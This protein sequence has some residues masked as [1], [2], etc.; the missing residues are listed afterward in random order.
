[1]NRNEFKLYK[2]SIVFPHDIWFVGI[3]NSMRMLGTVQHVD[4]ADLIRAQNAAIR[5]CWRVTGDYI[6]QAMLSLS[7]STSI[8]PNELK[9]DFKCRKMLKD[10]N[11]VP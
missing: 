11:A 3:E 1:M 9:D 7:E 2:S 6:R 10:K 8:Y 4:S 5:D